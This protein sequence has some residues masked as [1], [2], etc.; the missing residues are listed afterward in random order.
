MNLIVT[1][2]RNQLTVNNISNLTQTNMNGLPCNM[3][4]PAAATKSWVTKDNNADD[5]RAR[6]RK[7]VVYNENS[8]AIWSFLKDNTF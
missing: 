3:W 1:N 4:N 7:T 8:L 2:P 6:N 5:K